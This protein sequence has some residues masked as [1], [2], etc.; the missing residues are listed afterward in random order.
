ME[1]SCSVIIVTHN[2]QAFISKCIQAVLNQTLLPKEIHIIDS[3]SKEIDYLLAFEKEKR[4]RLHLAAENIG[5]CQGNNLGMQKISR[6]SEY[7]LFLNPDA[8]LQPHFF[9]ETL[10]F[11]KMS[12]SSDVGAL[13]SLLL[14]YD[15]KQD[16]PTGK[17]DSAGIFQSWY[18]R[19][20][21]R[22]QGQEVKQYHEDE[23]VPA[24]CGALM[25]CRREALESVLLE[26]SAV[27]DPSFFMYKEDIDLSLRLRHKGWRLVLLPRPLAYHCR[28]WETNR[29]KVS[30]KF[31]LMSARN[32]MRL[33]ARYRSPYF[34]YSTLKYLCVK[35]FDV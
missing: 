18:G 26:N 16:R 27:M 11:M 10:Q 35:I 8:Y 20:Y 28:G 17:I 25:L 33:H 12:S 23:E 5:F 14:G 4:V 3:G 19:W 22:D 34:L 13:S 32:E 24:L 2:S 21:D 30:R 29:E 1:A 9:E 15:N 31:R 7:V 6:D